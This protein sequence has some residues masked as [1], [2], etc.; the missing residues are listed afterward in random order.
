MSHIHNCS[1]CGQMVAVCDGEI[2][3]HDLDRHYCSVH[4][5]QKA[6]DD[7]EHPYAGTRVE[8]TPPP[9]KNKR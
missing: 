5:P 6:H 1:V 3:E 8:Q 2:C 7:P 9:A 4:V